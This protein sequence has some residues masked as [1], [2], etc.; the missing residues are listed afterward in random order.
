[1]VKLSSSALFEKIGG[2]LWYGAV[3]R[4][5]FIL[6]EEPLPILLLRV[7]P[8]HSTQL[9]KFPSWNY[10]SHFY[11]GPMKV[12][13]LGTFST[14]YILILWKMHRTEHIVSAQRQVRLSS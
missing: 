9:F 8:A 10:P 13:V 14:S 11:R 1:M 4:L 5:F 7:R 12:M 2:G 6:Q 3:A